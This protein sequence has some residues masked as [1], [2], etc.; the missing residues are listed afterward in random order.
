MLYN[1]FKMLLLFIII[2]Y[3]LML[4]FLYILFLFHLYKLCLLFHFNYRIVISRRLVVPDRNCVLMNILFY[5]VRSLKYMLI[6]GWVKQS[7]YLFLLLLVKPVERIVPDKF[8]ILL[9]SYCPNYL[10][11]Q[12]NKLLRILL[13]HISISI[14]YVVLFNVYFDVFMKVWFILCVSLCDVFVFCF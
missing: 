13:S 12:P 14:C 6:I 8:K 1:S 7:R 10:I 11:R 4:M 2:S 5:F 3:S 9:E